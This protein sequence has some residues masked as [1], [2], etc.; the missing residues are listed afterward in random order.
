MV[1]PPSVGWNRIRENRLK[2]DLAAEADELEAVRHQL[3][4]DEAEAV[5]TRHAEERRRRREAA[6]ARAAGQAEPERGGR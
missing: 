3:D 2:Q 6:E 1:L 5:A 4:G